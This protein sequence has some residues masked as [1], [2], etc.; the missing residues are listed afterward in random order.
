MKY[1]ALGHQFF[2]LTHPLFCKEE[3]VLDNDEKQ[4]KGRGVM[5]DVYTSMSVRVVVP[6][7]AT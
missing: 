2:K 6:V 4:K 1:F 5:R 7:F 3:I